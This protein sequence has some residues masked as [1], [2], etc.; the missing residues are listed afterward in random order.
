[1]PEFLMNLWLRLRALVL[2]RK[3]ERDLD[4]ELR[5]HLEMKREKL[6]RSGVETLKASLAARKRLGNPTL[7]RED[8]RSLWTFAW[9]EEF[10]RD[11]RYACRTMARTPVFTAIAIATLAF[12]IGANTAIFSIVNGVLLREMPY[13]NPS[14]LYSI[15]EAIESKGHRETLTCI[16]AGNYLEWRRY[17][18]SFQAIAAMMPSNDTLI[19]GSDTASIHGVRVSASLFPLLGAQPRMGRSFTPEED[20]MGHGLQMILTDALWRG[21]FSANPAIVGQTVSLNG[22]P[23]TVIG[24]LPAGFYFPKQDQIYGHRVAK[25]D[26]EIEY[27]LNLNLGK[28]DQ[29]P[30]MG[31][32]NYAAMGRIPTGVSRAR[33]LAELDAIETGIS[34]KVTHDAVLHA[35]LVPLQAGVVGPA[36]TRIWMLMGGAALVMAIV[37]VNLAG[38]MLGRNTARAREVAIR[39]A[40]GAS[41]W[42]VLRQLAA[43]GLALAIAGGAIGVAAAYAGLRLLVRFAPITLPRLETVSID[44]RVL[45]FSAAVALGAGLLFSVLPALWIE[46]RSV[47]ETLRSSS[48]GLSASGRN[49]FLHDLL[50]GCEIALCTCLLI[51]A[52]L[53]GQSLSRVLRDNAWLNQERVTTIEIGPSPKEYG[54]TPVRVELYRSLLAEARQSPGVTNVGLVNNLP[55]HGG[56]WGDSVDLVEAPRRGIDQPVSDFRFISPGYLEAIGLTVIAGR[57]FA[58]SDFGREVM[59]I[60]EEVAAQ[61]P[62]RSPV[63]M[64][65]KWHRPDT[66]QEVRLE[67]AGIVRDVRT[68]AEKKPPLT[69]YVPYWIWAPWDP[70]LVVRTSADP[71]GVAGSVQRMIRRTHGEIP[72]LRVETLRETLYGATASRRFLTRLGVVFAVSA[73]LLAALGIYGVVALATARRRREIAIRMAVGASHPDILGMV[74]GKAARLSA[75]SAVAGLAGGAALARAMMSLLYDVRPAEPWAYA[76]AAAV[77]VAVGL[78]AS[79]I[80]AVRAARLNPVVT[81]KCE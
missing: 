6:E 62:G 4:D 79:L 35:E 48:A 60:S 47:E 26:S 46:S 63:G 50:A 53:L 72:V 42:T 5:F 34:R 52:L 24:V 68:E 59:W 67:I 10:V 1:M 57:P 40:L 33:G 17:A 73:T 75:V 64:H 28:W 45:A 20:F 70:S 39:L 44:G 19:Q 25:W 3:L 7:L 69:V 55:L 32:F 14:E 12:G 29:Q 74:M 41:R 11:L 61:F 71:A 30:K 36:V 31:N 43:E 80:P 58:E 78:A 18:H 22:F 23:V 27:F 2:R 38:L 54:K 9:V 81:L 49:V 15:R 37:C 76:M 65:M 66:M 16:N 56:M 8:T 77:V 13:K 51:C 21:R